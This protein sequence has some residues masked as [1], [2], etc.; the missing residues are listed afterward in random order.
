MELRTNILSKNYRTTRQIAKAAYALLDH[1]EDLSQNTDFV[2]PVSLERNGPKP[3]Y[4]SFDSERDEFDFLTREIKKCSE[5]YDLHDIVIVARNNNYL[6]SVQRYLVSHGVDAVVFQ[7]QKQ[8]DLF[9]KD[10]VKLFTMHSVKGLESPVVFL[11]G[12]NQEILPARSDLID[13]DRK[14]LYVGMT[15]AKERLYMSNSHTPCCYFNEIPMELLQT[16]DTPDPSYEKF[17]L[18]TYYNLQNKCT[19]SF[20]KTLHEQHELKNPDDGSTYDSVAIP[21]MGEIAAGNLQFANETFDHEESLPLCAIHDPQSKFLLHVT[22]DS[23]IDFDIF[24]DDYLLIQRQLYAADGSIIIGGRRSM[25][26]ATVKQYHYDGK[27]TVTLHPGNP[28]YED[29]EIDAADFYINGVVIGVLR[30]SSSEAVI[31][32]T[33]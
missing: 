8:G 33:I 31:R 12:L 28:N 3:H 22:G 17:L 21:V 6:W 30:A 26:E 25:N 16:A 4:Q 11:V 18:Y 10:C 14:L 19:L 13:E 29:I 7:K 5:Q 20:Q 2:Q 15:R 32:S 24:E 23:M 9:Q 1:D 27:Q